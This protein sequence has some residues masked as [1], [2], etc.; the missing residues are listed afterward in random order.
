MMAE[1]G[2]WVSVPVSAGSHTE[3]RNELEITLSILGAHQ[4]KMS[5]LFGSVHH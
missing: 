5:R 2:F 3:F 4:M 1:D